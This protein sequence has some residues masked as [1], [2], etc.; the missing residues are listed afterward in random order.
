MDRADER[1]RAMRLIDA[2]ALMEECYEELEDGSLWHDEDTSKD[3]ADGCDEGK[4]LMMAIIDQ[5]PTIDA[6]EVVHGK[7]K[8]KMVDDGFNAD[9]VCS[10]CGYRVMTDFVSYSY[11]PNCGAKMGV[12]EL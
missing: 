2:D 12:T 10:E 11:C 8:R 1:K 4:R 5:A 7:W 3:Y 6:V 9:W